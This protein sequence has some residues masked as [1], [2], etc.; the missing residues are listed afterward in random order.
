MHDSDT[1]SFTT[2]EKPGHGLRLVDLI[3]GVGDAD[4]YRDWREN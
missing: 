4:H 2:R 3:H 1:L